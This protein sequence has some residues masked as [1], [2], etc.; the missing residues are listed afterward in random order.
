MPQARALRVP[1]GLG[2]TPGLH[3][4]DRQYV[5]LRLTQDVEADTSDDTAEADTA[6]QADTDADAGFVPTEGASSGPARATRTATS[7]GA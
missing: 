4:L 2:L 7:G 1:R 5:Y 3:C 6:P